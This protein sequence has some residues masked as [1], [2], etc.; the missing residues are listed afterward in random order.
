MLA[1]VVIINTPP[2]LLT[3]SLRLKEARELEEGHS[4]NGDI[5]AFHP[6]TVLLTI[7]QKGV[8]RSSPL[9]GRYNELRWGFMYHHPRIFST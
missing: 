9:G 6:Q 5:Q 1:I 8:E 3:M 2:I 4:D 7:M